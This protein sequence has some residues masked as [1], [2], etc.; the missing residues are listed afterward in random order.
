VTADF[1]EFYRDHYQRLVASLSFASPHRHDIEDVAQEA[2]ARVCARWPRVSRGSNP[3]GYL[4]R[5]AFR[6]LFR[7]ARPR[8]AA[9]S[10]PPVHRDS[11]V[12]DV[13]VR[14]ALE[15]LPP[16]QR[17]VAVLCIY[18]EVQPNEAAKIMRLR[19]STVRVHLH[20]VRQTLMAVLEDEAD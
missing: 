19:P 8:P 20:R 5:V 11:P 14:D 2:F 4:Y 17:A 6:L 13:V 9:A 10:S 12:I 16:K 1:S 18:L 7:R 15:L 3:P